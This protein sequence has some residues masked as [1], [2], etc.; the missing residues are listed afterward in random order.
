MKAWNFASLLG[1]AALVAPTAYAAEQGKIYLNGS[2]AEAQQPVVAAE[3]FSLNALFGG[4]KKIDLSQMVR[5]FLDQ[6]ASI[7]NVDQDSS[8]GVTQQQNGPELQSQ[9][10]SK[11]WK[12]L[13][14]LG[15]D[16]VVHMSGGKIA[17]ANADNTRL[18]QLS[19]QARIRPE[20]ARALAFASYNGRALHTS[21]PQLKVLVLGQGTEKAAKLVYEVTVR[22]RNE[23]ASDI[24]FIDAQTAQE[25]LVSTNVHTLDRQVV[26]G[27]GSES[28]FELN[29]SGWATVFSDKGC[30]MNSKP[31]DQGDGWSFPVLGASDPSP[32]NEVSEKVASSARYAWVNS[33]IVYDYYNSVHKRNSIDGNG[34]TLKSVVNFGGASFPNAAWYNDKGIMLYGMGDET[35]LNDFA[36]PLD[37]VAHE[38]THGITSRTSNLEYSDQSGALNE[39]YSDVFGKLVAFKNGKPADWKLGKELFKDGIRFVRDM[40]NPEVGHMDDY[41]YKG[42]FCNRFNDFCGVH[43]NSGIPNKAAVL[44]SKKIGLEKLG[45]IYFLTLTQLLRTNSDFAEA[46]AQTIA[47]CATLYG[48]G[49]LDCAAVG[50]AFSAVGIL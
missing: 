20:E 46:K 47:A 18:D 36:S 30:E 1:L 4:E 8:W 3:A 50:E 11:T 16:A 13:P 31:A 49:S 27:L 34:M 35:K 9:R 21:A 48:Q 28:D 38:T 39:S 23:F 15:G 7:L 22:D 40:E 33:G 37:V 41:M 24:H 32:C 12:G 29:D 45:K 17:F 19:S 25:L 10:M 5:G 6:N 44:L 43:S 14:V 42:Q 2:W 26:S